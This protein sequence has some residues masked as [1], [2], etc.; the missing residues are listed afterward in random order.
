LLRNEISFAG[1]DECK[2]LV[3]LFYLRYGDKRN[4]R[5]FASK[6]GAA[7]TKLTPAIERA[8]CAVYAGYGSTEFRIVEKVAGKMLRNHLSEFVRMVYRIK[9]FVDVP[10]RLKARIV[11]SSDSITGAKFI[12]TRA[13]LAARLL[14]LCSH[15]NVRDWLRHKKSSLIATCD[16]SD[17]DKWLINRIWP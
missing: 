8:M 13:Y 9:R 3:P 1:R 5:A 17:F 12:D 15:K 4:V 14:G 6:L 2:V 10:G 7:S 16:L 11:A